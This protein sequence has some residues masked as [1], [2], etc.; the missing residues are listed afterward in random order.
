MKMLSFPKRSSAVL[1]WVALALACSAILP[2]AEKGELLLAEDFRRYD[3]FTKE[4]LPLA[5]GWTAR[6]AHGI[7]TRTSEGV[8]S[9]E[10]PGHQPVLVIEG[11]FADVIVELDFRYRAER[12]KWAACRV[13]ATNTQL[14]PRAYA[15][16]VWAN[17]DY[18][19]RAVGLV[20]EHDQ[21]S[22]T[23]TQVARKMTEF[24]PDQWHT[25][26]LEIIGDQAVAS[27]GETVIRGVFPTFGIPKNS[28]WLATGLSAHELR[29]LRIYSVRSQAATA[30]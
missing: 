16:S 17:I 27:V 20:L 1:G 12:A 24:A 22:G 6:V 5:D 13:S 15:A 28:L 2:A 4:R 14:H 10:T 29:N 3:A 30:P 19:S 26:R 25:L 8:Q 18:R 21:W 9:L 23:V 7:W 11:A